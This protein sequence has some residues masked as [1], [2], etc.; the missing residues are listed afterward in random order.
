[1][2]KGDKW[3]ISVVDLRRSFS[4]NVE[5][6]ENLGGLHIPYQEQE[7]E[8]NDNQV[9]LNKE[10]IFQSNEISILDSGV[11]Y[12]NLEFLSELMGYQVKLPKEHQL[13]TIEDALFDDLDF[14]AFTLDEIISTM[15]L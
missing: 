11:Q 4:I 13:L 15:K 9:N 10:T 8:I 7:I 5:E 2:Q 12:L 3:F 14:T 1:M 6:R